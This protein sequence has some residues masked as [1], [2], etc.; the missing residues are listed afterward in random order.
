MEYK[1]TIRHLHI[2]PRKVGL[3]VSSVRGKNASAARAALTALPQRSSR[4]LVKLIDAAAAS[5]RLKDGVSMEVLRIKRFLVGPGPKRRRFMPRAFGRVSPVE[6]RMSHVTLVLEGETEAGGARAERG[7]A[8]RL[9]SRAAA[10]SRSWSRKKPTGDV[11]NQRPAVREA[12]KRIFR[13]KT[14]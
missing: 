8:T 7:I 10:T 11:R 4:S 2:T 9:S 6:K 5:A 1:A 14:I 13:R 3:L 12:G